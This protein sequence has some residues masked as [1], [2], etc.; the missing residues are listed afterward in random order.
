V[1]IFPLNLDFDDFEKDSL[2]KEEEVAVVVFLVRQKQRKKA[3]SS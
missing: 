3:S 1:V 2:D